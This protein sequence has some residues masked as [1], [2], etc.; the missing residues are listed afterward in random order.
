MH[1]IAVKSEYYLG[2]I[3]F[4]GNDELHKFVEKLNEYKVGIQDMQS[5]IEGK[6]LVVNI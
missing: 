1:W 3:G 6:R 4:V 5:V 2:V